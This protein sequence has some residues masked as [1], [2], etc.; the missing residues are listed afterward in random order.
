VD[1]MHQ[2]LVIAA[3]SRFRRVPVVATRSGEGRV[4]ERTPA[5]Q[6]RRRERVKVPQSRLST[7]YQHPPYAAKV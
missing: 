4:T 6:A 3:N 1:R 7:A 5:I 2:S